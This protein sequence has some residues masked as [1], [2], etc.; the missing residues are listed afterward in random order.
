MNASSGIQHIKNCQV[1]ND[2]DWRKLCEEDKQHKRYNKC[3]L[4]LTSRNMIYDTFCE[5]VVRAGRKTAVSTECKCKGW[6]KPC[7]DTIPPVSSTKD[8]EPKS[9]SDDLELTTDDN[10]SD[11]GT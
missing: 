10:S 8:L 1:I 11:S 7:Q 3:L 4:E 6:Y 9:E 5:A 2:S